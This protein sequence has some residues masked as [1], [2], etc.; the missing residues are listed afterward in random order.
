MQFT[1]QIPE[2]KNPG[3][4]DPDLAAFAEQLKKKPMHW[5]PWPKEFA[6][7]NAA[8]S[9]RS[10][11]KRGRHVSFRPPEHFEAHTRGNKLFVRYIGDRGTV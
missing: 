6:N 3:N 10:N 7:P 2:T 5:A 8:G 1:E 4:P 9:T 11:L